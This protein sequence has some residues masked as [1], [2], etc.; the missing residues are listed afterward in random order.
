MQVDGNFSSKDGPRG[1]AESVDIDNQPLY[2]GGLPGT[3]TNL[4][5]ILRLI[6]L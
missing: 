2:V 6:K 3:V 5:T 1:T 4:F